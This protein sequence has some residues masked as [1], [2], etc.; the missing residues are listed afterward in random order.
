MSVDYLI[1]EARLNGVPGVRAGFTQIEE[2]A[3]KAEGRFERLK[4][5]LAGG[6]ALGA[7][8]GISNSLVQ[9]GNEAA[10]VGKK[11][12]AM[13][14]VRANQMP[15][16]VSTPHS[17]SFLNR[18]ASMMTCLPMPVQNCSRLA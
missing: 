15:W 8:N 4:G 5:L 6:L 13:L 1:T 9:S 2:S 12:E 17:L 3:G 11:L 18:L 10:N 7:L 16:A 14:E